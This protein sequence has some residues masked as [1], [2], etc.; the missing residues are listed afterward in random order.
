M[1]FSIVGAVA[2]FSPWLSHNEIMRNE[3]PIVFFIEK[4]LCP[5]YFVKL[6]FYLKYKNKKARILPSFLTR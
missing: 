4:I 3:N 2:A 5:K 6:R 1:E